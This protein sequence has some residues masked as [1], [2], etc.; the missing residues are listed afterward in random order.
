M[1]VSLFSMILLNKICFRISKNF[2]RAIQIQSEFCEG[3]SLADE[4]ARRQKTFPKVNLSE[5]EII[6]LLTDAG[7]GLCYIHAQNLAHLDIKPPNILRAFPKDHSSKVVYK[8]GD[9]GHVSPFDER[10][11][12]EGDCRYTAK[13]LIQS[14]QPVKDLRPA[15]VFSLGL[16]AFEAATLVELHNNGDQ[17]Q[18]IRSSQETVHF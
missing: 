11:Y 18:L 7:E 14:N 1:L 10:N 15:D 9:L 8:I 16:S 2:T 17:W 5:N 6:S 12:E 3:G 4:I 13:E